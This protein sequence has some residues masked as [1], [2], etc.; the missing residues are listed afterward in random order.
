MDTTNVSIAEP[1]REQPAAVVTTTNHAADPWAAADI[2]HSEGVLSPGPN[3]E[4]QIPEGRLAL[5]PFMDEDGVPGVRCAETHREVY[6]TQA[7]VVSVDMDQRVTFRLRCFAYPYRMYGFQP[8]ESDASASYVRLEPFLDD[9]GNVSARCHD[10][11]RPVAYLIGAGPS[12]DVNSAMSLDLE[13]YA[14][15][16]RGYWTTMGTEPRRP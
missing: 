1:Q 12:Q 8:M 7:V 10:T 15:P 5:E 3:H 11:K 16:F 2:R 9:N 14:V 13:A 4:P 6:G